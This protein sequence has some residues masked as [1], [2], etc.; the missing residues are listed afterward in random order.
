MYCCLV[1]AEDV[2]LLNNKTSPNKLFLYSILSYFL[3]AFSG[4]SMDIYVPGLVHMA[5][6]L[7]A[8]RHLVVFTIAGFASGL[9]IGQLIAGSLADSWGRRKVLLIS[10]SVQIILMLLIIMVQDIYFIIAMR[11]LQGLMV[12]LLSVAGRA[13][14][15]DLFAGDELKKK[16][17]SM[18]IFW[19]LGPLCAPFIGGYLVAHL[20]WLAC[21]YFLLGYLLLALILVVCFYAETL[22]RT[23]RFLFKDLFLAF[24]ELLLDTHFVFCSTIAG[25]MAAFIYFFN[26]AAPF[27]I[28][29][30]F[31]GDFSSSIV[32]GYCSMLMG[33]GWIVGNMITRMLKVNLNNKV[34][35]CVAA[36][37]ICCMFMLIASLFIGFNLFIL[38]IPSVLILLSLATCFSNFITLGLS[39]KRHM[40]GVANACMFSILWVWCT[41]FA[42][43]GSFVT[44]KKLTGLATGY[45]FIVLFA[46]VLMLIYI[47]RYKSSCE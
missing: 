35:I 3:I 2:I 46:S 36:A 12:A 5:N 11:F 21:F 40:G 22:E 23:K 37:F 47:R 27:I 16:L 32:T 4:T 9:A 42:C 33:V 13:I 31:H 14:L 34:K 41:L 44:A 6:D 8:S 7:H 17:N 28:N 43:V 15:L 30:N 25:V 45:T 19:A 18:T 20:G 1:A 38:V 29:S 24:R 39:T 26:V 10:L